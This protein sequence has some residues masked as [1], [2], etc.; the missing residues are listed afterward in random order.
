MLSISLSVALE[1]RK[2]PSRK[3]TMYP[4]AFIVRPS[5]AVDAYNMGI[6]GIVRGPWSGESDRSH[7]RLP[8]GIL[9]RFPFDGEILVDGEMLKWK[10][11]S[12]EALKL[13]W[14]HLIQNCET[15]NM[16]TLKS[17]E[18]KSWTAIKISIFQQS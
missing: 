8:N 2:G 18:S 12:N 9:Q 11:T 7:R 4:L 10:G 5:N 3:E 15:R 1:V 6:L 14:R 16:E 17:G 13:G